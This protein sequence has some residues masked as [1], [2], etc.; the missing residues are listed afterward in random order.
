MSFL[1]ALTVLG[2][3]KKSKES[4]TSFWFIFPVY[5]FHKNVSYLMLYQLTKFQYQ[6]YFLCQDIKQYVV[7]NCCLA[8]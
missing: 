2:Y 4:G 6:T 8:N 5:F 1:H 3:Y 7:L